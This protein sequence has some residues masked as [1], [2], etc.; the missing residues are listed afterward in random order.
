MIERRMTMLVIM[1]S[2]KDRYC[3]KGTGIAAFLSLLNTNVSECLVSFFLVYL[4]GEAPS[5]PL[6][7]ASL[8]ATSL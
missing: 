6:V 8:K 4:W 1:R 2:P 5:L 3:G 7:T